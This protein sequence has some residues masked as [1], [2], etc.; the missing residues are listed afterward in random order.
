MN[1]EL[2]RTFENFPDHVSADGL[3]RGIRRLLLIALTENADGGLPIDLN[4]EFFQDLESL[5]DLLDDIHDN[6][7]I[8]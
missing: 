8:E 2:Q 3:S 4:G 5:F 6:Q 7:S 1:P